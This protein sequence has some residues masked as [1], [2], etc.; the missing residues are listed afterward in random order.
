VP[1]PASSPL[2]PLARR[3]LTT[4]LCAAAHLVGVG[5]VSYRAAPQGAPPAAQTLVRVRFAAPRALAA[6]SA[7]GDTLDVSGVRALSGHV[8]AARGDTLVLRVA[9]MDP[10]AA[11]VHG[12]RT[13]VVRTAV[14]Q[15][16]VRQANTEGTLVIVSVLAAAL[17]MFAAL[18]YSF[19]QGM[20]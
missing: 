3:R 18:A 13:T 1:E 12:W 10:W 16:S 6:I 9:G 5:C 15:V 14:D 4:A 8:V 2:P 19:G 7:R 20:S 11:P 17:A